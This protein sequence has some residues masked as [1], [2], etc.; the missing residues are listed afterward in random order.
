MR[1]PSKT[2]LACPTMFDRHSR[3]GM[4]RRAE[5]TRLAAAASLFT[6]FTVTL[7]ITRAFACVPQPNILVQPSASGPSGTH[8]DVVGEN[9]GPGGTEVRWNAVDGPLLGKADGPSF[10]KSIVIPDVAAGLYTLL[11]VL[12]GGQGEVL[13]AVRAPFQVTA[14]ETQ[15]NTVRR[16]PVKASAQA[17]SSSDTVPAMAAGAGI[18]LF[19]AFSGAA[20]ARARRD[21]R[22]PRQSGPEGATGH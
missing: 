7:L 20:V 18:A 2:A 19:A 12:R 22:N 11:A 8:V 5:S 10:S 13:D 9:F 4:T 16:P 15:P 14:P 21:R 17:D 6:A 3:R 1:L